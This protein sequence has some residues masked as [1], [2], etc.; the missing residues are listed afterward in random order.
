LLYPLSYGSKIFVGKY[1]C[2]KHPT[3]GVTK[4]CPQA[5]TRAGGNLFK[6]DGGGDYGRIKKKGKVHIDVPWVGLHYGQA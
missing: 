2:F 5:F 4:F 1:L 3:L 6:T